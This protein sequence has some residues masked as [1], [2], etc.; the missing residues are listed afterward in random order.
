MDVW[1][2]LAALGMLWGLW[3]VWR[4]LNMDP[5]TRA[6]HDAYHGEQNRR[7]AERAGYITG[8]HIGKAFHAGHHKRRLGHR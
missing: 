5:A 3:H 1:A 2:I 4:V 6:K 7:L 8:K